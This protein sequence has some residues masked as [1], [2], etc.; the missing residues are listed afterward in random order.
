M[1][2]DS[3]IEYIMKIFFQYNRTVG[4]RC[5]LDDYYEKEGYYVEF[6]NCRFYP[7]LFVF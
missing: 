7:V 4:K 6:R 2:I 1:M 3:G 5:K